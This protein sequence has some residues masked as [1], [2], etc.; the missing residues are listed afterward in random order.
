MSVGTSDL[1]TQVLQ[2]FVSLVM[3]SVSYS[4]VVC[5]KYG[6]PSHNQMPDIHTVESDS[7]IGQLRAHND[8]H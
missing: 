5:T 8:V 6:S 1:T 7:T 2:T 3:F 4:A